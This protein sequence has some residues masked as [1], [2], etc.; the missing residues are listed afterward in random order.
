MLVEEKQD[1]VSYMVCNMV[2]NP[3]TVGCSSMPRQETVLYSF[4]KH[5]QFFFKDIGMVLFR[6]QVAKCMG[7]TN[8]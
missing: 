2:H 4:I 3:D 5:S 6:I 1:S 7:E 8:I